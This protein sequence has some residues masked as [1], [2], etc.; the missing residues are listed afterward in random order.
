MSCMPFCLKLCFIVGSW[1]SSSL[2]NSLEGFHSGHHITWHQIYYFTYEIS[3]E[4]VRLFFSLFKSSFVFLSFK[5]PPQLAKIGLV[6]AIDKWE[7]I[8]K[9]QKLWGI[10]RLEKSKIKIKCKQIII[11]R[12]LSPLNSIEALFILVKV[13]A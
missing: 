12:I 8:E 4:E 6:I 13:H 3:M 7:I 9:I 5:F 1:C 11:S 2:E 10:L